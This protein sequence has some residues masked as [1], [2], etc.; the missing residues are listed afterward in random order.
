M[1][2]KPTSEE[3]RAAAATLLQASDSG[4]RTE[5]LGANF[6]TY[7]SLTAGQLAT[8]AKH[9]E[10]KFQP[11]VFVNDENPADVAT[12]IEVAPGKFLP[13]FTGD[14][15]QKQEKTYSVWNHTLDHVLWGSRQ[16][17]GPTE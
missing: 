16:V 5:V 10:P 9:Q 11:R 8:L 15:Y 3:L 2:T 14:G 1:T 6:G 7:F 13:V 12:Y 17:A 4:L